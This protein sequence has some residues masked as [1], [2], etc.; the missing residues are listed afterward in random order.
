ML[1]SATAKPAAEALGRLPLPAPPEE[2]VPDRM[3]SSGVI[4]LPVEHAHTLGVA[5]LPPHGRP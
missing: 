1:F 2:Y 4:G 5:N 3:E